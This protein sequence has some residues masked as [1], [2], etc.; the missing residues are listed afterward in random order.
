MKDKNKKLFHNLL[1]L[2]LEKRDSEEGAG[3]DMNVS[4]LGYTASVWLMNV[5]D[6]K[7]TGAKEYYTRIG[8]EAWAKTKGG[9]TE[10]VR[11]EDVLEA[12]RNA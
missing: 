3:I 8:D 6:G 12:L 9:K 4:T 5:E 2:V 1:D 11:D 7:I 10:I